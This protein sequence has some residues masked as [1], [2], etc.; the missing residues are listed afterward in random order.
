MLYP[1]TKTKEEIFSELKTTEKG[2]SKFEAKKRLEKNGLNLIS[3]KKKKSLIWFFLKQFNSPLIYIL[4]VA[5]IISFVF[6]H[7]VDAYVILAVVLV[8]ASIGFFQER[9]AEKS[10]DA[11]KKLI[12]SYAKVYRGGEIMKI[13]A[14]DL[15]KGDVIYLEAGD[16]VPADCRLIDIKNFRTQEASLTGESFPQEKNLNVLMRKTHLGDIANMV[17]MGTLV[18]SGSAKAVV[19]STGNK[20]AIG[21]VAKSIEEVVQPKMHFREKVDQLAMQMGIFAVMGSLTIFL[22]GF[23]IRGLDFFEIFL[24][25]IASLVSG[26]PEGLPA[27][28]IIVL[29]IGARRMAKRNA[30]IRHLPAVETLGVATIIATD[31]TG[32]LTQN[33]LTIEKVVTKNEEVD[34]TGNGWEPVGRF[35]I[36]NKLIKSSNYNSLIK[37][38]KISTL[39]NKGNLLRK[40][41]KYEIVGDPTEVALLV[42]GKKGGLD[43][44]KLSQ[45]VIDD[46]AFN[47]ELKFRASLIEDNGKKELYSVGAFEKIIENSSYVIDGNSIVN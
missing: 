6:D 31:K 35:S 39:C 36:K 43:K 28:L 9:K 22:I 2:L 23:F 10:I 7:L 13:N 18:V 21:Q 14:Q 42:L 16:K 19:T 26:I 3:K 8:N 12:I 1:H 40:N 44:E 32:T 45:K 15:V 17:F 25:T 33:S 11:L 5:M 20:T 37:T 27:V 30:I 34:I 38:L 4:F 41:G 46:L 29:A 24:F 47:S